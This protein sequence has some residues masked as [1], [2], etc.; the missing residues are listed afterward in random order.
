MR[1]AEILDGRAVRSPHSS[2]RQRCRRCAAV[3]VARSRAVRSRGWRQTRG[4]W[5]PQARATAR[6]E[7]KVGSDRTENSS[8]CVRSG[9]IV[10]NELF[11]FTDHRNRAQRVGST[12]PLRIEFAATLVQQACRLPI[13]H[14]LAKCLSLALRVEDAA[15][16]PFRKLARL[17]RGDAARGQAARHRHPRRRRHLGRNPSL[18]VAGARPPPWLRGERAV[19]GSGA[20]VDTGA[21]VGD[22]LKDAVRARRV[23][24][25]GAGRRGCPR[26]RRFRQLAARE[27][28]ALSE[29]FN[30][31]RR[32][33]VPIPHLRSKNSAIMRSSE[34]Q[35]EALR[36]TPRHSEVTPRSLRGHS[37]VTPRHSEVTPRL[38]RM[39]R[40]PFRRSR[41]G[42]SR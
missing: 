4:A 37:E 14:P 25:L 18:Q 10:A 24:R 5:R 35:S 12:C 31:R 16:N 39:V 38:L 28:G 32:E 6:A 22:R 23:E 40:G 19:V 33:C 8:I 27:R 30:L 36:V 20:V 41:R 15:Q 17:V 9:Q 13:H 1:I 2:S 3:R 26:R 11:D 29:I 34:R 42:R 21:V 7:A